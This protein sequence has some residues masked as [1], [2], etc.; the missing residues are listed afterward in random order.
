[1]VPSAYSTFQNSFKSRLLL[2]LDT[3]SSLLASALL[4]SN[5]GLH[6]RA[7]FTSILYVFGERCLIICRA[8]SGLG[9]DIL[10]FIRGSETDKRIWS[11]NK[12]IH[13]RTAYFNHIKF[14]F[15][16]G[17]KNRKK[18]WGLKTKKNAWL[19]AE[20]KHPFLP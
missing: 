17:D 18:F 13:T 10:Y 8:E 5:I 6:Y 7:L 16:L 3:S 1:M 12:N 19:I 14:I 15:Q 9:F 4:I 2:V 20:N 11:K